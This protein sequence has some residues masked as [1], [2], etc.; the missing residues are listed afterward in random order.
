MAH[1]APIVAQAGAVGRGMR[2]APTAAEA[3]LW[4]LLRRRQLDGIGFRRQHPLD[5]FVVDFYAPEYRLAVELDGGVHE[6]R[7]EQDMDRDAHLRRLGIRV[8]RVPNR[9][10]IEAPQSVLDRIRE[11]IARSRSE[12]T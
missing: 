3:K 9:E 2:K 5:R 11:A 6:E 8:L 12:G 1:E 7:T 4:A 10:V